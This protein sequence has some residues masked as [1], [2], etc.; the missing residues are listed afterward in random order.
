MCHSFEQCCKLRVAELEV[1]QGARL[2]VMAARQPC[3]RI[4]VWPQVCYYSVHRPKRALR[5]LQCGFETHACARP[6]AVAAGSTAMK[7][8]AAALQ[9]RHSPPHRTLCITVCDSSCQHCISREQM[10]G[11]KH[12]QYGHGLQ[13]A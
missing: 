10:L 11:I 7:E 8:E 2:N 5:R 13:D 4:E 6:Q 3:T 12:I 9:A 1:T